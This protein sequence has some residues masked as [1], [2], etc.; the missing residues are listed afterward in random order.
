MLTFNQEEFK[1][2]TDSAEA[3]LIEGTFQTRLNKAHK[4]N[5]NGRYGMAYT[6]AFKN[7]NVAKKDN[8]S[9]YTQED[10]EYY[11]YTLDSSKMMGNPLQY[12]RA[13]D[14]SM[15]F[16]FDKDNFLY[17]KSIEIYSQGFEENDDNINA[18]L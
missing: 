11:T 13:V 1:N 3:I 2:Y 5:V 6:F 16:D 17:L 4:V 12:E 10:I 15:I 8:I 9:D 7:K 18:E 14:Q